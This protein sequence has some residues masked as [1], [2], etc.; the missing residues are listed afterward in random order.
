MSSMYFTLSRSLMCVSGATYYQQIDHS[1][2]LSTGSRLECTLA[3]WPAHSICP[4]IQFK[5]STVPLVAPLSPPPPPP[6][7][8]I[9]SSEQG[10]AVL[11]HSGSCRVF[12]FNTGSVTQLFHESP[13]RL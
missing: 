13:I 9:E 6:V 4:F 1:L 8:N 10:I 3:V 7:S 11:T 2:P 12:A 5:F